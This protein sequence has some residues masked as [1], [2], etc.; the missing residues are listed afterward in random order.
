MAGVLIPNLRT[1]KNQ[2]KVCGTV[3]FIGG[4]VLIGA[5]S[6]ALAATYSDVYLV[7]ANKILL[8]QAATLSVAYDAVAAGLAQ[9]TIRNTVPAAIGNILTVTVHTDTINNA[10]QTWPYLLEIPAGYHV[11][12]YNNHAIAIYG[13]IQGFVVDDDYFKGV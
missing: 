10:Q 13:T 2:V 1:M 11:S 3:P 5:G 4:Q 8:I 6:T 7:P 9:M 12:I